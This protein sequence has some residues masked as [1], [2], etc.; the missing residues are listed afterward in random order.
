MAKQTTWLGLEKPIVFNDNQILSLTVDLFLSSSTMSAQEF[1]V[2]V[3]HQAT[4]PPA[5]GG[6]QKPI[7]RGKL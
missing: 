3:L 6:V 4:P 2:A 5:I 1:R 7:K